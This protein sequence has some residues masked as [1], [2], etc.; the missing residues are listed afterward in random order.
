MNVGMLVGEVIL[1]VIGVII[2][3]SFI[4]SVNFTST[5]LQTI[6]PYVPVLLGVT[7]IVFVAYHGFSKAR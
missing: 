7:A 6:M 4:A 2:L 5:I 3:Q 1:I